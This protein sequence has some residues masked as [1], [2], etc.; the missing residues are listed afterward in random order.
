MNQETK[1]DLYSKYS[2]ECIEYVSEADERDTM[3]QLG[4]EDGFN[5]NQEGTW[6]D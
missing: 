6:Y 2:Q 4:I 5:F 3:Q 1:L